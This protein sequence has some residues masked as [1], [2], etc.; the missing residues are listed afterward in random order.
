MKKKSIAGLFAFAATVIM[1]GGLLLPVLAENSLRKEAEKVH[2]VKPE[3]ESG[4]DFKQEFSKKED[5]K[6]DDQ[7][8][9]NQKQ[10]NQKQE[11][12]NQDQEASGKEISFSEEQAE[13][14]MTLGKK[15]IQEKLDVP[16]LESVELVF[17]QADDE[18]GVFL[19]WRGLESDAVSPEEN[20]YYSVEFEN[21][22]IETGTGTVRIVGVAGN[23]IQEM[24]RKL[25]EEGRSS[26]LTELS[27]APSQEN[28]LYPSLNWVDGSKQLHLLWTNDNFDLGY[29]T[30]H[31]VAYEEVNE[32]CTSG[33]LV[34][35][36]SLRTKMQNVAVMENLSEEKNEELKIQAEEYASD[37]GYDI[38]AYVDSYVFGDTINFVFTVKG[39]RFSQVGLAL[40]IFGDLCGKAVGDDIM[41]HALMV[42]YDV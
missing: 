38:D 28:V 6:Q 18:G 20:S 23:V 3:K 30:Y 4:G 17:H 13:P 31:E 21:A 37:L 7:K 2:E 33:E 40:N 32:D 19:T 39:S 5:Q 29:Y 1:G 25:Q 34:Y 27:D 12:H 8:Q 16:F 10:D 35:L 14:F 24:V 11:D 9:E 36:H 22:D 42:R 15:F 26:L 41:E